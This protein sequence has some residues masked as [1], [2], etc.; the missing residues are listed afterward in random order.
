MGAFLQSCAE[1]EI[2]L[3]G[4]LAKN[5][6]EKTIAII[7]TVYER[8]MPNISRAATISVQAKLQ[9]HALYSRITGNMFPQETM[10]GRPGSP[11]IFLTEG[12]EASRRDDVVVT[13]DA[14][15]ARGLG[16]QYVKVIGFTTPFIP[17]FDTPPGAL[18][19]MGVM[20]IEDVSD[21]II[22]C[23]VPH[24]DGILNV[25]GIDVPVCPASGVIH[26]LMYYALSAEIV[27]GFTK[28]GIYPR[29]G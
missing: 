24:T 5:Y 29:I 1:K 2:K 22:H 13:N 4:D 25:Q 14:N 9:G 12:I 23:H 10:T 7:E 28:S 11:D 16:E 3:T 19:N 15:V 6:L 18:E 21:I 20:R 8:E 26:S 17:N 27:E